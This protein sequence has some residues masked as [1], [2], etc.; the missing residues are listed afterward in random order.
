MLA[1][2]N[3]LGYLASDGQEDVIG[4]A[5]AKFFSGGCASLF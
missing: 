5:F 3:V 1:E 2:C 4:T